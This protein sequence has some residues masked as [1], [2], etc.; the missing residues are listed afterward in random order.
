MKKN[1]WLATANINKVE[2]FKVLLPNYEVKSLLDF[3]EVLDIP[4][5]FNTFEENS[6]FKAQTL[7]A[8][9]NQTVIADDSGLCIK[10]LN[11]FPGVKSARWAE[12]EKDWNKINQLLL[13]KM[14]TKNLTTRSQ[15]QASFVTAI[16]IYNKQENICE[17][18]RGEISGL[19]LDQL[20]GDQGFGY[21]PIFAPGE[22]GISFAQMNTEEKNQYSHRAIACQ[23]LKEFLEKN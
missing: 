23:K 3:D 5:D 18:F 1:I 6:L 4:E 7:N 11:D 21:D 14:K 2:E 13:E 12:P 15:R 16:A 8:L 17:V 20:T 10:G 22:K 19:I 9:I